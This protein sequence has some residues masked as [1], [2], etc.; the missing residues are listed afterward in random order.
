MR[1]VVVASLAVAG[2]VVVAVA[3]GWLAWSWY[4]SRLPSTYSVMDY[5]IEDEGGKPL[6][7][8]A[9]HGGVSVPTLRGPAGP[10]DRHFTLTAREADVRLAS[11]RVV[12][13]LTF[14][15]SLPGPELRVQKGDLVE[16]TLRN[17]DVKSGV[18]IHWHGV[19]VP[20]AEDGVAGVTQ[21]AVPPGAATPTASA[22][23]RSGRSGTTPTS[24]EPR[25]LAAGSTARS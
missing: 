24:P 22:S 19:D 10:P 6:S 20:N 7:E 15:G 18:T 17:Q 5:A 9:M 13:A 1:R 2:G 12:H 16:V 3:L 8:H 4:E 11:G 25:R 23:I 14:N 21:N